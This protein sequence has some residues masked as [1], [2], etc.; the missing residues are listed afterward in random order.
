MFAQPSQP[1][2]SLK[3]CSDE[4][5]EGLYRVCTGVKGCI[6]IRVYTGFMRVNKVCAGL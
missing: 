1:S 6:Y 5:L 4:G 3:D 2:L